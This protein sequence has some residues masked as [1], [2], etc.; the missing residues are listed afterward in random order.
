MSTTLKRIDPIT[1]YALV[2]RLADQISPICQGAHLLVC[3]PICAL[4]SCYIYYIQLCNFMTP[5]S[6]QNSPT[7]GKTKS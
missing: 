2:L 1:G 7:Y 5:N 3:A 4:L 6:P